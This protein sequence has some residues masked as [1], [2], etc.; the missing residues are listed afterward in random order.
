[1]AP[2]VDEHLLSIHHLIPRLA[3]H[4][5]YVHCAYHSK[6]DRDWLFMHQAL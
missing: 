3:R 4:I 5:T 6:N 2:L 1:M